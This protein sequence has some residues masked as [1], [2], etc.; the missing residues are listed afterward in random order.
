MI[1][2][3]KFLCLAI[4]ISNF[5]VLNVNAGRGCCSHHGGESSSCTSDGRR[6]CNDGT[7][8]PS[9]TCTPSYSYKTTKKRTTTRKTT[10]TTTTKRIINGC[11]D[12]N[13]INY[14]IEA[15]V[16]DG[17]CQYA[18]EIITTEDINYETIVESALKEGKEVVVQ[19]GK[20]GKKEI[21]IKKI[22]D[23]NNNEISSE[24]IEEKIVEEPINKIIKYEK[25]IEN[26]V[27]YD[28]IEETNKEENNISIFWMIL[29]IIFIINYN[30]IRKNEETFSILK[31]IQKVKVPLKYI[32]Y[33]VYYFYI[34]PLLIDLVSIILFKLRNGKK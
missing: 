26:E 2:F 6:I 11:M 3:I 30:F 18:S 16:S 14:N 28:K 4:I 15:N 10:T 5:T 17:T 24:I 29:L 8:S 23:E 33:I 13:A 32:L 20:I 34:Y 9:C 27:K 22:I 21:I 19:E 31:N 7:V 12:A 1:K 25:V